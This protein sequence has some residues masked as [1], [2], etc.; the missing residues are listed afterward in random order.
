M[1]IIAGDHYCSSHGLDATIGSL[2]I[3]LR[4]PDPA[5]ELERIPT[6]ALAS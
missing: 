2:V 4:H 5:V 1:V 6:R 3:D